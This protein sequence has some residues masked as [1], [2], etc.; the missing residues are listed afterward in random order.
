MK[1]RAKS[2][3][4]HVDGVDNFY[5][6]IEGSENI[7]VGDLTA[8]LTQLKYG[9]GGLCTIDNEI[10]LERYARNTTKHNVCK[11][12]AT[13]DVECVSEIALIPFEYDQYL[14]HNEYVDVTVDGDNNIVEV[15]FDE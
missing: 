8:D 15:V 9:H 1:H 3:S 7:K 12:I 2:I 6:I 5:L 4:L 11:V 14:R 10:E 13:S